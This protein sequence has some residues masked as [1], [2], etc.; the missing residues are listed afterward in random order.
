MCVLAELCPAHSHTPV[1]RANPASES[2]ARWLVSASRCTGLVDLGYSG[3][4]AGRW[5]GLVE[6][7]E[8]VRPA[9]AVWR[10]AS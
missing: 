6:R 9:D 5:L 10:R 7:I 4:V 3:F 2:V 8:S 1:Q